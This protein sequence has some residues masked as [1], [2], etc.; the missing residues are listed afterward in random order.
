MGG[1]GSGGSRGGGGGG[2]VDAKQYEINSRSFSQIY[3][4]KFANMSDEELERAYK[5][6][7]NLMQ[8]ENAKYEFERNKL[9]K[10]TDEYKKIKETDSDYKSKSDS[11]DRQINKVSDAQSYANAREQIHH[12]ALNERN[13]VRSVKATNNTR[14]MTNAQLKS[15]Y[16]KSYKEGVKAKNMAEK[17]NNK[18]TMEKYQKLCE[19]HNKNFNQAYSEKTKRGLDGKGW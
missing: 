9:Q 12:L 11:L 13:N 15:F 6:S 16:N 14:E 7:R 19:K 17:T 3:K 2:S 4:D 10:M 5:N 1:R 18:K 8:K